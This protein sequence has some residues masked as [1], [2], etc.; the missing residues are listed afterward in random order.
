MENSIASKLGFIEFQKGRFARYFITMPVFFAMCMQHPSD[1]RCLSLM[2]IA[3]KINAFVS[4]LYLVSKM[5]ISQ[6]SCLISPLGVYHLIPLCQCY[7]W[8]CSP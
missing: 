5:I 2:L 4:E 7:D 8:L 3:A 6:R 1:L